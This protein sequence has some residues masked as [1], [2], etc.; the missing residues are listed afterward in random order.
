MPIDPNIS[1]QVTGGHPTE[2]KPMNALDM[3]GSLAGVQGKLN[4]LKL[5]NQTFQARQVAGQILSSAPDMDTGI[6]ELQQNPQTS[7]FAPEIAASAAATYS[8]L[9]AQRGEVQRQGQD[10]F[11]NFILG[12]PAV[13]QDPKAFKALTQSS[14]ALASS[15]IRPQLAKSMEYMRS[16]LL[17]PMP[18]GTPVTS[19]EMAKRLA[20]VSIAAGSGDAVNRILGTPGQL[21]LG[22][23][24]QPGVVTPAQGGTE[25][26]APGSFTPAGNALQLSLPPQVVQTP[27]APVVMGG[28]HGLSGGE[29]AGGVPAAI[30]QAGG[31][32]GDGK[33]LIPEDLE[34]KSPSVGKGIGGLNVLSSAQATAADT[35]QKAWGTEGLRAFNNANQTMGLLTEM[36][37]DYDEMARGGGFLV[38]GTAADLRGSL[39]KLVN[40]V[41]QAVDPK[42]A[43]PFDASKIAS[44]EQFTK[45]T[46]RMGLTV[47]TTMLGNQ[48]EAAQTISNITEAVPGI[49]N[50]YLGGKLLI[51]SIRAATQRAIDQRNFE[52]SWQSQNQ[53]NLTGAEEAFNAA[54]PAADYA[55]RVLDSFGLSKKGFKN[56]QA[57]R[58]ASHQGFLT[59]KQAEDI[60]VDEFHFARP[61]KKEK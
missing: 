20:G 19:A 7:A 36:D 44:I 37:R 61:G 15:S 16:F 57:V 21:S 4:E 9:T 52:N 60:L 18:D 17:D 13:L 42:A 5:F 2:I 32:A 48:R 24:V 39:G 28:K 53:G 8:N 29:G 47:L 50:T 33:P 56:P 1:L 14:L 30:P 22:G 23:E 51:G 35:Q 25:G 55:T 43:P 59:K 31:Q 54:H 27:S 41:T 6:R 34:M 38:P 11:H 12:M 26:Q 10:A 3:A 49:N 40:T 45:D 58:D 46:R